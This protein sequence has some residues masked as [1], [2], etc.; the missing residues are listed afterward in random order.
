MRRGPLKAEWGATVNEGAPCSPTRAS[1]MTGKYPARL[2]FTDW[3]PG[4]PPENPKLLFERA[5]AL[6]ERVEKLEK[7]KQR[8][9]VR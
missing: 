8:E 2:H 1:L 9:A 4:Q 3:I 6:E 5:K 7:E